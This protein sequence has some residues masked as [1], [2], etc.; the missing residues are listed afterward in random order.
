MD[1]EHGHGHG[2]GHGDMDMDT[3]TWKWAQRMHLGKLSFYE[4]AP[5]RRC[6]HR[7]RHPC[8][9][10]ERRPLH[11]LRQPCAP[12]APS[13]GA[14]STISA[15]NLQHHCVRRGLAG[16]ARVILL[17]QENRARRSLL[18]RLSDELTM[19]RR[20]SVVASCR[21][22]SPRARNGDQ[23]RLGRRQRARVASTPFSGL[24]IAHRQSLDGLCPRCKFRRRQL[25]VRYSYGCI[26]ALVARDAW[27]R[28]C[29]CAEGL[30]APLLTL[31]ILPGK[32]NRV[33]C[34]T[35]RSLLTLKGR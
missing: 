9:V 28:N 3:H 17:V 25:H 27:K 12:R 5:R 6:T 7:A 29:T 13:F 4:D 21:S 15:A 32:R 14:R 2:H 16:G 11:Q 24:H 33:A 8:V 19:Q 34:G 31:F 18:Q 26:D 22:Y 10:R 30:R 1:M 35:D 20:W 23:L